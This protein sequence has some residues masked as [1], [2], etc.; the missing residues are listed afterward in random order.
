MSPHRDDP[1]GCPPGKNSMPWWSRSVW[2]MGPLAIGFLMLLAAMLGWVP[3]NRDSNRAGAVY[4]L[5]RAM[6]EHRAETKDILQV[7]RRICRNTAK[8][9]DAKEKCDQ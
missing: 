8:S 1:D 2:Q 7:L 9:E 5:E 3:L 4:R 6:D